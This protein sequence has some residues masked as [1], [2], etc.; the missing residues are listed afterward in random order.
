MCVEKLRFLR[1]L[2]FDSGEWWQIS[3]WNGVP[4]FQRN[5]GKRS[6]IFQS[7]KCALKRP[8]VENNSTT[9]H[10]SKISVSSS[11]HKISKFSWECIWMQRW[12]PQL[13]QVPWMEI[14]GWKFRIVPSVRG[15]LCVNIAS[16]CVNVLI[17]AYL[18]QVAST[19]TY[20]HAHTHIYIC[21]YICACIH[22]CIHTHIYMRMCVYIYIYTWDSCIEQ[23][24]N[25]AFSGC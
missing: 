10:Y 14:C 25:Q 7:M 3:G 22:I 23:I 18:C 6:I 1:K 15:M 2:S 13:S 24:I 21:I 5:P 8:L 11:E 19:H 17:S 20:I 4:E 9:K 16:V 12:I